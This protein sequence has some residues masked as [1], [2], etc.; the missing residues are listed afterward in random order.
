MKALD[1]LFT[2][3]HIDEDAILVVGCSTSEV[4]GEKIGTDGR[5]DVAR[6]VFDTLRKFCRKKKLHLAAQCC[7][8]L[9]R[10]LVVEKE[11][12]SRFALAR[13]NAIPQKHAG[14]AFATAAWKNM[15]EPVLVEGI[16]ADFGIDIGDT[17]IGMHMKPVAVP[18][19]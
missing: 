8:H 6:T 13:V 16:S 7:E 9:N 15:K 10:S 18:S 17:L 5:D 19:G 3:A 12:M 11:T 4:V 2:G 14:G 1:G